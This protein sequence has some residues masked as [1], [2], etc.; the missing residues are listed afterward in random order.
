MGD[1]DATHVNIKQVSVSHTIIIALFFI[2]KWY[3][4]QIFEI[5]G[6]TFTVLFLYENYIKS[7]I[8]GISNHTRSQIFFLMKTV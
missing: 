3:R 7:Q 5:S 8:C 6:H 4:S 1:D 2:L